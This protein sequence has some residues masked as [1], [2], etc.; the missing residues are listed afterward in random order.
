[1]I[2]KAGRLIFLQDK[3]CQKQAARSH[4]NTVL[5]MISEVHP[6]TAFSQGFSFSCTRLNGLAE[7]HYMKDDLG[8]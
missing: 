8:S 2:V 3:E 6:L 4:A 7:K 1:M 5:S